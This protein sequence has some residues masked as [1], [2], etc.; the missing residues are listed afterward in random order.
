MRLASRADSN[1][2]EIVQAL[3]TCGA[4]VQ[5]IHREGHGCPDILCG[6]KGKNYLLEIKMPGA[7]L[8]KDELEWHSK[9]DGQVA[10]VH[11]IEEA[12]NAIGCP[13]YLKNRA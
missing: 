1:Q 5:H 11:S 6:Y 10:V 12:L 9:W 2:R 4:A 7:S 3:R 13:V 8:T